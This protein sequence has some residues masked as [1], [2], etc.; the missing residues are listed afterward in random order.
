M[1]IYTTEL[2]R[3]IECGF[4]IGLNDYP[5]F[6]E[7]YR[8]ILNQKIIDHYYMCEIG[9]ETAGLFRHYL[10]TKMQEIMP[11]YNRLYLSQELEFNPLRD[12]DETTEETR[13]RTGKVDTAGEAHDVTTTTGATQGTASNSTTTSASSSGLSVSSDTPQGML[14]TADITNNQYASAAQKDEDSSSGSSTGSSTT[15]TQYNDNKSGDA[16]SSST[17]DTLIDDIIGKHY[18]GYGKSKSPS[19]LLL[20][21]RKTFLNIDLMIIKEL[22]DL[23]MM[24]Y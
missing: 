17:T 18:F 19:E 2:R 4:D 5:I 24:I 1:A 21:Y 3:L 9:A 20:E 16:A 6:D 12:F 7:D 14:A 8:P 23:F 11:Y 13:K 10:H 22:E 15:G